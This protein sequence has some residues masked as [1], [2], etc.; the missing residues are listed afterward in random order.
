MGC[1]DRM[2]SGQEFFRRTDRTYV[3]SVTVPADLR[4]VVNR[5][6]TSVRPRSV[7]I[8]RE[9]GRDLTVKEWNV[10][11]LSVPQGYDPDV[12]MGA[13]SADMVHGG[14]EVSNTNN[15]SCYLFEMTPKC[16]DRNE[17]PSLYNDCHLA[18]CQTV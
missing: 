8:L 13:I 5:T 10:C 14:V 17:N 3:A 7:Q 18:M 2:S 4:R 1:D 11:Y 15:K 9:R 12:R 16:D 6:E